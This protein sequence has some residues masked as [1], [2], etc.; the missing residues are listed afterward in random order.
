MNVVQDHLSIASRV[1]GILND[2][3]VT[4]DHH[5]DCQFY[6]EMIDCQTISELEEF[7]ISHDWIVGYAYD[8]SPEGERIVVNRRMVVP[9]E[10]HHD[11]VELDGCSTIKWELS[12]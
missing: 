9:L 10:D 6:L 8:P 7:C 5:R 1:A 3:S 4:G 11:H 12:R 2:V